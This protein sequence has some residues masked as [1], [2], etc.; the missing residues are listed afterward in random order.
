MKT[1]KI[2]KMSCFLNFVRDKQDFR[3]KIG[4]K[5]AKMAISFQNLPHELI[6]HDFV[7]SGLHYFNSSRTINET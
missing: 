2:A 3:G 6:C 5:V 7:K 1:A 4:K